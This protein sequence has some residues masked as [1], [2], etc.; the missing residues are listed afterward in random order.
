M[1]GAISTRIRTGRVHLFPPLEKLS[2][3]A[4]HF[5]ERCHSRGS[6]NP[7]IPQKAA[8]LNNK[9]AYL[10]LAP[11]RSFRPYNAAVDVT[12]VLLDFAQ[13]CSKGLPVA[14]GFEQAPSGCE[15]FGHGSVAHVFR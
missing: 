11:P 5:R 8:G 14:A 9:S 12:D 13:A 6:G 10:A 3:G 1:A 2:Q 7:A 4:S 15:I